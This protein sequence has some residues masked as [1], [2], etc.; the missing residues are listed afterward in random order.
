MRN[1]IS[2]IFLLTFLFVAAQQTFSQNTLLM[3]FDRNGKSGFIDFNGEIKIPA[4]F[5]S[6]KVFSDGVAPVYL[7]GKWG[8]INELGQFVVKPRFQDIEEFS[9]GIGIVKIKDRW[10]AIDVNGNF[11]FENSFFFSRFL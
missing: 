4:Q 8:V 11:L 5:D 6:V 10:R 2:H 1:T 7:D 3:N 9:E